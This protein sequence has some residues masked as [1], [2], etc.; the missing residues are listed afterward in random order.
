MRVV[1]LQRVQHL[2]KSYELDT[3][4]ELWLTLSLR[5]R[6]EPERQTGGG[7]E[8]KLLIRIYSRSGDS[9]EL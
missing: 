9:V 7:A 4:G 5:Q 3:N 8:P 1:W 2:F 6:A